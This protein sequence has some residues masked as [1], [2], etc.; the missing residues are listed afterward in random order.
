MECSVDASG[1][2]TNCTV[3]K[4]ETPKTGTVQ[5]AAA[6]ALQR[7]AT[8]PPPPAVI[9]QAQAPTARPPPVQKPPAD[10]EVSTLPVAGGAPPYPSDYVRDGRAG[11]VAVDCII[12]A[13]GEPQHCKVTDV[14]GGR[15]F[16][17]AAVNWLNTGAVRFAPAIRNGVPVAEERHWHI[18]FPPR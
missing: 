2:P 15:R 13:G 12:D 8:P 4:D 3:L 14:L 17:E 18:A 7:P 6:P 5:P 11:E 16:A 9:R 1:V 10:R